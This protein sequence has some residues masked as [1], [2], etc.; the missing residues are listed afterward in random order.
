LLARHAGPRREVVS[1][2]DRFAAVE[3]VADWLAAGPRMVVVVNPQ[4]RTVTVLLSEKE[5][6]ILSG[7]DILDV[8]EVVPSCLLPVADVFR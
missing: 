2:N 1:P 6:R 8:G 4:S 3:K 7:Q 5:A